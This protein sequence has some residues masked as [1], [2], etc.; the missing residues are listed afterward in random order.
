[1]KTQ[2]NPIPN[3][4]SILYQDLAIQLTVK[5]NVTINVAPLI[6]EK[7]DSEAVCWL[8]QH[9]GKPVETL[10]PTKNVRT[11]AWNYH[12]TGIF[13]S[14]KRLLQL[15]I[16]QNGLLQIDFAQKKQWSIRIRGQMLRGAR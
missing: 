9:C 1:M 5:A 11:Y 4:A 16:S 6:L 10:N 15:P 3:D 8:S 12:G 7:E 2:C 13:L 14:Q